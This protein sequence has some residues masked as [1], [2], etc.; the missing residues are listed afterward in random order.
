M[1]KI[2]YS[3]EF[4]LKVIKSYLKSSDGFKTVA[5]SFGII[6][7]SIVYEWVKR[8]QEHGEEGLLK[9]NAKKYDGNFKI[10][11]VEYMHNNHLSLTET[12]VHFR[13]A[14]H[15]VVGDWER[16]Y[17]EKGPQALFEERRGKHMKMHSVQTKAAMSASLCTKEELIAENKQFRMENAYLKKLN[18][19]VQERIQRE[20]G[21]K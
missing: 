15:S 3:N 5:K 1:P 18:A 9:G 17:N 11:V 8:Y 14:N 10:K 16:I 20:N 4:K 13:L 2:K 21:K 7:P 19:L 12:A 6:H